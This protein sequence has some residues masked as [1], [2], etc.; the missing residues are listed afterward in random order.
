MITDIDEADTKQ[1]SNRSKTPRQY[2]FP[3]ALATSWTQTASTTE[4][5]PLRPIYFETRTGTVTLLNADNWE[6]E[7]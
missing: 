2:P 4:K 5:Y 6:N 7:A 1:Q 3:S